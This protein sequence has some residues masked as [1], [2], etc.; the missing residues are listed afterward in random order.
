MARGVKQG[1]KQGV[2]RGHR[3]MVL[4]QA[5]RKFG[6]ETAER[7]EGLV[8]AMGPEQ[9][10]Q[11]GHAVAECETGDAMLAEAANGASGSH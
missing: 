11:V 4:R 5:S 9:L 10:V 8:G 1:V 7:L 6:A 2:A 3:E